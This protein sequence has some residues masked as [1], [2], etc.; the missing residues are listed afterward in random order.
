M[1]TY[2]LNIDSINEKEIISKYT[3]FSSYRVRNSH[4]CTTKS[5]EKINVKSSSNSIPCEKVT[6]VYVMLKRGKIVRVG[7]SQ[8]IW[9]RL[10]Q[11]DCHQPKTGNTTRSCWDSFTIYECDND[12]DK[13]I[14]EGILIHMFKPKFNKRIT[15][16]I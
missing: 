7:Q 9:S 12:I 5:G 1:I 8:D 3:L 14:I 4:C 13:F 10:N 11:H 15:S 2:N 6:G 16:K